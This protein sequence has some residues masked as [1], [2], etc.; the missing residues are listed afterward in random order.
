MGSSKD[1]KLCDFVI[2]EAIV[3]DLVSRDR[4]GVI[5][6]KQIGEMTA[7]TL[8]EQTALIGGVK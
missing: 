2:K 4:N 3:P 1:V 7:Q 6:F 8:A 5:R